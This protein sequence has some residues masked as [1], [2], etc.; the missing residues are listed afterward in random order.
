MLLEHPKVYSHIPKLE[1]FGLLE[2][3][4]AKWSQGPG[5]KDHLEHYNMETPLMVSSSFHTQPSHPVYLGLG[6]GI[7]V[8]A[9]KIGDVKR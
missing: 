3:P 5:H 7:K 6:T 1:T 9:G 4:R 8:G 2:S